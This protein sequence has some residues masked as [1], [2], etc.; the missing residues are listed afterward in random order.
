MFNLLKQTILLIIK[1][2]QKTIS[3]DT[4][5]LKVFYPFGACRYYPTCSEYCYQA[6]NK[7][8]VIKGVGAGVKRLLKC[9]PLSKGGYDPIN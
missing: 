3:P 5:V 6:V 4:G 7:H 8:G 9:H 2:Y 1:I